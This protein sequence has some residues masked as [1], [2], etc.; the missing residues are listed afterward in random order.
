MNLLNKSC[1]LKSSES[2][3]G[4][5]IIICVLEKLSKMFKK[6]EK[7]SDVIISEFSM[8]SAVYSEPK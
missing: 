7:S 3:T 1:D 2:V 5:Q 8:I 6:C 4:D